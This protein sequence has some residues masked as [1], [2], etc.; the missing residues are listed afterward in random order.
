MN[1][2]GSIGNAMIAGG[3]INFNGH[4]L[5]YGTFW[6]N[7]DFRCNGS[8]SLVGSIVAGGDITRNGAFNF[9]QNNNLD[10]D[11]LPPSNEC[12]VVAW[13]DEN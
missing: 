4:S 8:G 6:C 12:R 3:N 9:V 1:A 11:N 13:K 7:G 2:D 10:N 5:L